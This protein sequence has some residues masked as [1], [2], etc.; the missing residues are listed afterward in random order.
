MHRSKKTR[1]YPYASKQPSIGIRGKIKYDMNLCI[2]CGL[3][4]RDCP[5]G[6]IQ[7]IG[8]GKESGFHVFLDRCTF[9]SQCVDTCP[10]DAIILT[11]EYELA[12]LNKEELKIEF[13]RNRLSDP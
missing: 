9:C 5:S 8:K 13:K 12:S 6:A 2:G 7:M 4:E 1:K 10:V 11:E 3:C